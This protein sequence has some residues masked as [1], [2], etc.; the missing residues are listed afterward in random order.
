SAIQILVHQRRELVDN[1]E[2]LQRARNE[3]RTLLD[4][5]PDLVVVQRAGGIVWANRAFVAT[6]GYERSADIIGIQLLEL[7]A[8]RHR[9]DVA[10]R[11][12]SAPDTPGWPTVTRVA[13]LTRTGA[14]VVVEASPTQAVVFDGVPARLVVGRDVTE[15]VRMQQKLIVADRLASIGLL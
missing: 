2:A 6:L 14:E 1:V 4:R 11:M 10:E 7:V 13:L 9:P 12:R 8:E 3:L 15:R 5:L